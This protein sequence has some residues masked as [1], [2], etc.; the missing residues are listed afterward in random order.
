MLNHFIK[1]FAYAPVRFCVCVFLGKNDTRQEMGVMEI[2][3]NSDSRL[4]GLKMV[5]LGGRP[6]DRCPQI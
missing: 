6:D 3:A 4:G 2:Q 1:A 5:T